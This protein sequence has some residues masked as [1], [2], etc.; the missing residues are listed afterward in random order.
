ME[1]H[2][3]FFEIPLTEYIDVKHRLLLIKINSIP[4]SIP[5]FQTADVLQM[6]PDMSDTQDHR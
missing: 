4:H 2:R 1:A 3:F 5:L 6:N